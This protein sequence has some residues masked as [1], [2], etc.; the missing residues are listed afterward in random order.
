MRAPMEKTYGLLRYDRSAHRSLGNKIVTRFLI[1]I[2]LLSV[3]VVILDSFTM[4]GWYWRLSL[5][6]DVFTTAVFTLEYLL[7]LW[8]APLRYPHLRPGRARLRYLVSP[9]AIV[10]LLAI[11]PLYLLLFVRVNLYVLRMLRIFR[12]FVFFKFNRYSHTLSTIW[13]VIRDKRREL[14]ASMAVV[15]SLMLISSALIYPI[16]VTAQPDK[17]PNILSGLWW[18]ISTLLTIGYGD[19]YPVTAA[20]KVLSAIVAILGVGLI[21]VPTGII[22]AGFI[23]IMDRR[24]AER[25]EK[26]AE[27]AAMAAALHPAD[28]IAKYKRLLDEGAIT[29]GEYEKKKAELLEKPS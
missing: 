19:I 5:A 7:R 1:A 23:E 15:F 6:F 25:G 22:S 9:G 24:R 17:F 8:T 20:G 29:P 27:R 12:L 21:A 28:E 14:L 18:A 13:E 3:L 26:K 11:L 10:D 4:P 16:E 2:I